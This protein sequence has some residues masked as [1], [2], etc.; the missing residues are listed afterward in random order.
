M[1]HIFI[2]YHQRHEPVKLFERKQ[3]SIFLSIIQIRK[4]KK[5]FFFIHRWYFK[6]LKCLHKILA[7]YTK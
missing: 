5:Y 6:P 3:I 4:A 2:S 7:P 1:D